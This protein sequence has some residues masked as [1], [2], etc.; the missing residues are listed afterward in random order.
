MMMMMKLDM[1]IIIMEMMIIM[2]VKMWL[3]EL[4]CHVLFLLGGYLRE[5]L[6]QDQRGNWGV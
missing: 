3:Y 1:I 2:E 6:P 5:R 4:S